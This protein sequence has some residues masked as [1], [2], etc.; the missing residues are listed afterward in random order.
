MYLVVHAVH[1][2]LLI[3]ML[4]IDL[5][6]HPPHPFNIF[7]YSNTFVNNI[8]INI[9]NTCNKLYTLQKRSEKWIFRHSFFFFFF[10]RQIHF[11]LFSSTLK[12]SKPANHT[13][14]CLRRLPCCCCCWSDRLFQY[15]HHHHNSFHH[16][17]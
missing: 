2:V 13:F 16:D 15:Y 7:A 3:I 5:C 17:C 14:I 8:I 1:V 9:I 12:S 4:C 6:A 11:E 10:L